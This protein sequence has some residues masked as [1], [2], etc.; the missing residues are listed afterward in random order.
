MKDFFSSLLIISKSTWGCSLSWAPRPLSKVF[1]AH[2][3]SFELLGIFH[4]SSRCP[5]RICS[6]CDNKN[7]CR[8]QSVYH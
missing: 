7:E 4:Y 1:K 8:L 3:S 5:V 2:L 6:F